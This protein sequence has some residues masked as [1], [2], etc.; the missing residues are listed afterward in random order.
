M[1]VDYEYPILEGVLK[2]DATGVAYPP[3]VVSH[4]R[5]S[6]RATPWWWYPRIALCIFN[7]IWP[8]S[9]VSAA[10]MKQEWGRRLF[11][12]ADLAP[13]DCTP[14][15]GWEISTALE[16][17]QEAD[18]PFGAG[19]ELLLYLVNDSHAVVGLPVHVIVTGEL[20]LEV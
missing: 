13:A 10:L 1:P 16:I 3:G 19:D 4:V 17:D 12:H 20:R 14:D 11:G 9:V 5:L 2:N 18:I 15:S 6:V 7:G 8:L